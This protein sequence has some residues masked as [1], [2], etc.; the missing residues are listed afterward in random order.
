MKAISLFKN[1]TDDDTAY[2]ELCITSYVT[3]TCLLHP[4][5][6]L[7][8]IF[9]CFAD[10]PLAILGDRENEIPNTR[11]E[12]LHSGLERHWTAEQSSPSRESMEVDEDHVTCLIKARPR[13]RASQVAGLRLS[14]YNDHHRRR[15]RLN[16]RYQ[17]RRRGRKICPSVSC[18][19]L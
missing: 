1:L 15:R 7:L 3:L 8:P 17:I 11:S 10:M 19:I 12:C 9:V 18:R 14:C 4:T 16:L 6:D 13:R 2:L 5:A